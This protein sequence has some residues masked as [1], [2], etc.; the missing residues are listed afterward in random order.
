VSFIPSVAPWFLF[1]R[2]PCIKLALSLP[3]CQFRVRRIGVRSSRGWRKPRVSAQASVS[4]ATNKAGMS[5]KTRA[6]GKCDAQNAAAGDNNFRPGSQILEPETKIE[7]NCP[8]YYIDCKPFS[9]FSPKRTVT[10]N[11]LIPHDM[12]LKILKILIRDTDQPNLSKTK[13]NEAKW[14]KPFKISE[15][16]ENFRKRSQAAHLLCYHKVR[17][18]KGPFFRKNGWTGRNQTPKS[19]ARSRRQGRIDWSGAPVMAPCHSLKHP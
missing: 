10:P 5:H 1:V 2:D 15:M 18:K 7:T 13:P 14:V 6:L 16:H 19:Q 8:A 9:L 3:E 12:I 11:P 17:P 4:K